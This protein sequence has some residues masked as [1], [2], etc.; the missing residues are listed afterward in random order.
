[1]DMILDS[2][3]VRIL[4]C[5]I[6]KEMATPEYYP[7]SLNS[8]TNACNQKSNRNPVL[9]LVEQDVEKGLDGL[10][11]KGL[12]R[13]T[14][15]AGSRV[16]K[17]LHTLFDR[18]DLSKQDFA[19]LCELFLRGPQTIGEIR[20]HTERLSEFGS[21]EAAADVLQNLSAQEPPLVVLLPREAGRK[22]RRYMHLFS[23]ETFNSGTYDE[24]SAT[25]EPDRITALEEQVAALKRELDELKNSLAEFRSQF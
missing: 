25:S 23:G 22:E 3:E 6:E 18:F 17:F 12:A 21:I 13:S 8:L 4:G 2:T 15:A 20:S 10:Q 5:L 16:P 1:M 14:V 9:S 7:L 24:T 11:K 19:V